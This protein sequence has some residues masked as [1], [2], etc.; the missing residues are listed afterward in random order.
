MVN[1]SEDNFFRQTL[2]NGLKV[3]F[4][5]R[6]VP[7]VAIVAATQFGGGHEGEGIKG[8][9]HLLEHSVLKRTKT[10]NSEQ[11]NSMIEK[12]GGMMNAFTTEEMTAFWTKLKAEHFEIGMDVISDVMVNPALT[13][14]DLDVEKKVVL[15]EIKMYRDRPHK[16]VL[17]KLHEQLYAPPFGMGI[18]GKPQT[19]KNLT[20]ANIQKYHNV[21][22]NPSNIVV[23]VVGRAHVDKIWNFSRKD[24]A[25]KQVQ[26]QI[27][28]GP[29]LIISPGPMGNYVEKRK[30]IDQAHI[31]IGYPMPSM[32]DPLRYAA[33][34]MNTILGFGASSKLYQEIR[35]KKGY[36]YEIKS[37]LNQGIS[38]GDGAIYLGTDKTKHSIAMKLA[39]NELKKMQKVDAKEVEEAKEQLIGQYTIND[40]DTLEAATSLLK[41]ELN[42]EGKEYYRYPE[43]IMS[44]TVE[45]VRKVARIEKLATAIILPE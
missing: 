10:K 2:P 13:K 39:L 35:E 3:I 23:S 26:R 44:V 34:I 20:R 18:L 1:K 28:Q 17:E 14:K 29:R 38:F 16:H 6:D 19:V 32:R 31:A 21:H 24:F 30:D 15:E 11:I 12:K 4:E 8:M 33:E 7:T 45:D 41:E 43:R 36:V 37:D 9:A 40:E 27:D 22:Y 5:K 42:G 25:K